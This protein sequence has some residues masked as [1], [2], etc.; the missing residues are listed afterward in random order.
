MVLVYM[1]PTGGAM[2]SNRSIIPPLQIDAVEVPSTFGLIGMTV[3]P[4]KDEYAG[5]GIPPGPWK[6]DLDLDLQVILDWRTEVLVSLIEQFE[7]N[8]LSVPK[9]PE[10][11]KNL[12]IRWLH[13]PIVDLGIPDRRFEEQWDM[14]G[15]DL[16]KVLED[17]GR[18][19]LHCRGGLGRTGTI[20]ARLLVEFG[21]D[22]RA[23]IA[24][25]RQ[26]RPGAIQ[27]WEQEDYVR[28]CGKC[29]KS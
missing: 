13:L 5:L 26:A 21:I 8:A 20:A 1:I 22:P 15:R 18:I 11:T 6:R 25:V 14:A 19:V 12:G 7:F 9:L 29:L 4:G 2:D 23:A 17:G 3:C 24:K 16:R 28:R 10:K 27:T